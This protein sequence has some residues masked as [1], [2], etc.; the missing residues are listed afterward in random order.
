MSIEPVIA[1]VIYAIKPTGE[2]LWYKDLKGDG[3]NA[4]DGS[5]GWAG[6]NQ[7]DV[8]WDFSHAFFGGWGNPGGIIYAIKPTGELLWYKDLKRDGTNAP[9][10]ST[11][12]AGP[13]QI[14]VGWD[15]SHVFTRS[16]HDY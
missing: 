6:C 5:T 3:T 16:P 14:G 15:F 7:I 9:D 10:G 11:G 13:K 8:G 2:L 1:N 4:P 12:W